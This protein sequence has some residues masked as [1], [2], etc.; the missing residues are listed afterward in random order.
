MSIYH[1]DGSA[2]HPRPLTQTEERIIQVMRSAAASGLRFL[3][4]EH[5][6]HRIVSEFPSTSNIFGALEDLER[7]KIIAFHAG[8]DG[9]H[10][11]GVIYA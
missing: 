6:R 8:M 10:L 2:T 7:D 3:G 9:Y 1:K 5:I 11:V 4:R